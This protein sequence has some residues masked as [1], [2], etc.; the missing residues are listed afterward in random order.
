MD[1]VAAEGSDYAKNRQEMVLKL[2][3][4]KTG[5]ISPFILPIQHLR[6]DTDQEEVCGKCYIGDGR[7]IIC[8]L[9]KHLQPVYFVL[10]GYGSGATATPEAELPPADGKGWSITWWN[11]D[12]PIWS[13][14]NFILDQR[15]AT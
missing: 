12:R 1:V 14:S 4:Q 10:A 9:D 15:R 2:R 11:V 13:I 3:H 7:V 8:V 5:G 6:Q